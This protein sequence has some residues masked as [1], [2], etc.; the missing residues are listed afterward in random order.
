KLEKYYQSFCLLDQGFVK[1]NSEITVKEHVAAVAKRLGDDIV[2][3]RFI[4]FQVGE[5]FPA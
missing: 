1:Q 3:R 2:I 5:V 4:R